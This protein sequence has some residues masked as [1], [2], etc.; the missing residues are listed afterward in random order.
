MLD[1]RAIEKLDFD[2]QTKE[3]RSIWKTPKGGLIVFNSFDEACEW[4]NEL[5]APKHWEP[6]CIAIEESGARRETTGGNNYDGAE[7]WKVWL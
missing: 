2:G 7:S 3:Y 1:L 5:R 6:V 4:I